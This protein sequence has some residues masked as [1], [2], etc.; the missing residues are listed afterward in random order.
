M[1]PFDPKLDFAMLRAS[2]Y[3]IFSIMA[4]GEFELILPF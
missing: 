2:W 3:D 1:M 4:G